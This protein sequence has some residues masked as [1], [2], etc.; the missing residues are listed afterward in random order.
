MIDKYYIYTIY[1]YNRE[2]AEWELTNNKSDIAPVFSGHY[3]DPY[4]K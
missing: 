2:K 4:H 1:K 3:Y